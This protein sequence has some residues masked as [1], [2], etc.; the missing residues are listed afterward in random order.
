MKL[1]EHLEHLLGLVERRAS[2][3]EIKGSLL[4]M[5]QEMEG[6]QRASEETNALRLKLD[7]ILPEKERV[8]TAQLNEIARLNAEKT[9]QKPGLR[10]EADPNFGAGGIENYT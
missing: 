9:P 3:A 6:A 2:Y 8:I 4:A 5:H 10:I 1:I 7:Q